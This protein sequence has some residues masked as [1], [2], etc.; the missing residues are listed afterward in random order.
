MC[1]YF[2]ATLKR[3]CICLKNVDKIKVQKQG[4]TD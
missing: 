1:T 3:D 4:K 2:K